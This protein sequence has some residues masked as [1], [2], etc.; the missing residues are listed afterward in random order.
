MAKKKR[1][2][3][4]KSGHPSSLDQLGYKAKKKDS[5]FVYIP[6]KGDESP[7]CEDIVSLPFIL[8]KEFVIDIDH[9]EFHGYPDVKENNA[10]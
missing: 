7:L 5:K 3:K 10:L 6:P 8:C 1:L 9:W 4:I 2:P